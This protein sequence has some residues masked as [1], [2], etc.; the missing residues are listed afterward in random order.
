MDVI[1]TWQEIII[2]LS[3]SAIIGFI[4]GLNREKHS[5]AGVRTHMIL[6]LGVC[7]L[8][9]VQ[10]DLTAEA[11]QWYTKNPDM[12]GAVGTNVGRLTAQI[13]S[14]IGFLGSGL[15]LVR[16]DRSIDGMTSAVSLWTVMG[17]SI[18]VGYGEYLVSFLG[19]VML[20]IT[21]ILLNLK[22]TR[23]GVLRLKVHFKKDEPD[24]KKIFNFVEDKD[25]K[26]VNYAKEKVVDPGE[27]EYRYIYEIEYRGFI[28]RVVFIDEFLEEYEN[29]IYI[30]LI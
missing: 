15:I 22:K 28:D 19:T 8:T 30:E 18:A 3:V 14:G 17:I 29:T 16:N 1:L 4:V 26:I 7:I 12:I 24:Q 23:F 21:L 13:V 20:L 10:V 5:S 9:L 25:G 6:A 27:K 11:I 2:R